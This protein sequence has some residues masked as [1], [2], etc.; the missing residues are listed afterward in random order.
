MANEIR[1]ALDSDGMSLYLFTGGMSRAG[2]GITGTWTGTVS[3]FY[4]TDGIN[5]N[6]LFM[7][8]FASGT[9]VKSATGNGNFQVLNFNFLAIKVVFSKTTGTVVVDMA[10]SIDDSYQAAFLAATSRAVSQSVAGG[11]TNVITIAAQA[12]RAWRCRTVSVGFSVAASLAI[13]LKISD[14]ASS[15]LWEGYVPPLAGS[16]LATQGGTWVAPLPID[17]NEAGQSGGG[18]VN[19]PG[20]SLVITLAAPGGSVVST[21][22]AEIIPN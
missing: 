7:T 18:V 11:A 17:D 16:V 5:F 12:N 10:A 13:D 4:S 6:P 14:G 21:V 19:T 2:I 9:A 15:V 1:Q 20:N 3:F 8:P 22:N